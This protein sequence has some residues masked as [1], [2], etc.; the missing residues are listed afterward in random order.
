MKSTNSSRYVM[1]CDAP[2]FRCDLE[3]L[4]EMIEIGEVKLAQFSGVLKRKINE[5]VINGQLP[6][7][8]VFKI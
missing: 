4:F 1:T 8:N 5:I 7:H 6:D 3:A 2:T